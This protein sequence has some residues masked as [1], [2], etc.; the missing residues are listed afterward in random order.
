ML[1]NGNECEKNKSNEIFRQPFPVRPKR[2]GEREFFK[3]I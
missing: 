1:W 3:N 2:T